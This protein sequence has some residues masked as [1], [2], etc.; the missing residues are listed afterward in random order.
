LTARRAGPTSFEAI[1]K[2]NSSK[3]S[4]IAWPSSHVTVASNVANRRCTG[5][6]R[7]RLAFACAP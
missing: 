6:R 4:S 2:S 5:W 7:N 3:A 1:N